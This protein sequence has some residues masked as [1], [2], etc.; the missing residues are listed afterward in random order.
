[1]LG[2]MDSCTG[3]EDGRQPKMPPLIKVELVAPNHFLART[4]KRSEWASPRGENHTQCLTY[5]YLCK[6]LSFIT[7]TGLTLITWG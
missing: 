4:L 6:N 1:M 7:N 5:I 3:D 2:T